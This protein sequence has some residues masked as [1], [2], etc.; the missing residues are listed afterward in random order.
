MLSQRI[1]LTFGAHYRSECCALS[2]K[3]GSKLVSSFKGTRLSLWSRL[4][5]KIQELSYAHGVFP[6]QC[7][8]QKLTILKKRGL[9][10]HFVNVC[11]APSQIG[12]NFPCPYCSSTPLLSSCLHCSFKFLWVLV[13]VELTIV[14]AQHWV[15]VHPIFHHHSSH[16]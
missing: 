14:G 7:S 1:F 3:Q 11:D 6:E 4:T 10:Q 15:S 12:C 8:T 2:T 13:V 5:Q 16:T 9:L